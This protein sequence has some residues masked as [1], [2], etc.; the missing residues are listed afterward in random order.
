MARPWKEIQKREDWAK[1]NVDRNEFMASQIGRDLR[2]H[3]KTHD[4][5]CS[6]SAAC[7]P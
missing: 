7:T 3:P 2:D 6:S 4:T 5:R 1:Y